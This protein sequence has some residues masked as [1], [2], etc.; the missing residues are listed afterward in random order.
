MIDEIRFNA[1]GSAQKMGNELFGER[2]F[3]MDHVV[4]RWFGVSYIVQF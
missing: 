2:W 3:R 1:N 4:R